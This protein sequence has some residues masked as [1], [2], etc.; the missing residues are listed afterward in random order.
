[1]DPIF[2]SPA[3]PKENRSGYVR[4]I[5]NIILTSILSTNGVM[6]DWLRDQTKQREELSRNKCYPTTSSRV[7]YMIQLEFTVGRTEWMYA[8]NEIAQIFVES[9]LD[10]SDSCLPNLEMCHVIIRRN[11][12]VL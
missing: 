12:K 4:V 9:S 6:A 7:P 10:F 11:Y 2:Y 5:V 3:D 1:M 8:F